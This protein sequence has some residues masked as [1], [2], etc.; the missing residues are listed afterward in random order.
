VPRFTTGGPFADD[1]TVVKLHVLGAA[2][3]VPPASWAPVE[4]VAVKTVFGASA[5][6][7]F[8]VAVVPV[9]VT[10]AGT[11]VVP[12][13]STNVVVFSV[14]AVIAS[15]NVA[16]TETFRVTPVA[17]IAG[18][19]DRT[20]GAAFGLVGE[21]SQAAANTTAAARSIVSFFMRVLQDV[22]GMTHAGSRRLP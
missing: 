13:R 5:L 1:A 9:Y 22:I 10:A 7:G 18:T 11:G 20:V 14:P 15:L 16:V 21:S 4:I 8:S 6:V 17:E 19:V 12:F 3:A 2:R